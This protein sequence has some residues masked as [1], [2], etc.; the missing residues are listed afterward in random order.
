M[1]NHQ[2]KEAFSV[3]RI[4]QRLLFTD[5]CVLSPTQ[6]LELQWLS[7]HREY[8]RGWTTKESWFHSPSDN[9]FI[10]SLKRTERLCDFADEGVGS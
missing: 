7:G 5:H 6:E 1:R 8:D 4:L 10:S 3:H 2:G 9:N